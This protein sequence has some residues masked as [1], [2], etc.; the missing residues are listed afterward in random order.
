MTWKLTV[1]L[2]S[3]VCLV[4]NRGV[5]NTL[6]TLD[7]IPGSTVRGLLA[8]LYLEQPG[9]SADANF[10]DLFINEVVSYPNLYPEGA[11]VIP[12]SALTCKYHPGFGT[13]NDIHGAVD[14]VLPWLRH[15][16]NSQVPL[17]E[18]AKVCQWE[19]CGAPLDRLNG[20]Y[21]VAGGSERQVTVKKRLLARTAILETLEVAKSGDL[22][23]LEVLQEGQEFLG[24]LAAP[25]DKV[26]QLLALLAT[27]S[28][29]WLGTA[30]SRGLGEVELSLAEEEDT[31]SYTV[32]Q[33]LAGFNAGLHQDGRLRC[34]NL[35]L[36]SDAIVLDELL[37]YRCQPLIEDLKL[38]VGVTGKSV[39]DEFRLFTA[40]S[41][42][43]RLSGWQAAW[44][45]PKPEEQ[46]IRRGSVFVFGL[47]RIDQALDS[48]QISEVVKILADLERNGLGERPAEGFGRLRVCHEFHWENPF[49]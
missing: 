11:Q 3:P 2:L 33:R 41:G 6:P 35:T 46:A 42:V 24:D 16:F 7:Y 23:S 8:Q 26:Q 38:A 30:R 22:Y 19:G 47:N 28:R 9:C 10:R 32:G 15:Q 21:L 34:F 31:A 25:S 39:L 20:Y 40:W 18:L 45:L 37:G 48:Q 5:G 29:G 4:Q 13:M 49:K 1:K 43:Q 27:Q 12:F 17:E 44:K 14:G 36:L